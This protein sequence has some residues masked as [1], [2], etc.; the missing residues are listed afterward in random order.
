M[1][2]MMF[3]VVV[4]SSM[5]LTTNQTTSGSQIQ[6]SIRDR[7]S[8]SFDSRLGASGMAFL[9]KPRT[10]RIHRADVG[11]TGDGLDPALAQRDYELLHRRLGRQLRTTHPARGPGSS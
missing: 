9:V 2:M 5:F 10:E 8:G 3:M 6:S 11:I 4:S 1:T 7:R